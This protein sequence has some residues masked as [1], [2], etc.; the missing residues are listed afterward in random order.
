MCQCFD[1]SLTKVKEH[2]IKQLGN[3]P[4][5]DL[6]VKWKDYSFILSGKPH[7]PVNPKVSI[8]YRG[9][10]RNGD[11]KANL[12]KDEC[13]IMAR[14]CPFCGEDKQPELSWVNVD[15]ELP[16]EAMNVKPDIHYIQLWLRY[17]EGSVGMGYFCNFE[18]DEFYFT[19]NESLTV[20]KEDTRTVTH[21]Q[22]CKEPEFVEVTD[23]K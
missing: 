9:Q 21:W 7:V 16:I 12:T 20:C 17:D 6:D 1:S 14:Y 23:A 13:S 11:W 10:K 15:D 3:T 19:C 22:L 5:T 18:M 2:V 4:Y 8:E